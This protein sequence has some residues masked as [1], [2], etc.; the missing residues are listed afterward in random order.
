MLYSTLTNRGTYGGDVIGLQVKDDFLHSFD[1][2]FCSEVH[3][4]VFTANVSGNLTNTNQ[5]T[6]NT[7]GPGTNTS[8]HRLYKERSQNICLAD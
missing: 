8:Y 3:F 4:V 6:E 2:F 1:A 7:A 5:L